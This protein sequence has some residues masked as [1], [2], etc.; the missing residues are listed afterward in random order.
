MRI[1]SI[2]ILGFRCFSCDGQSVKLDNLT[3]LVGPNASGKTATMA[4]LLRMFGE[5]QAERT[6][7][8]ADFYLSPGEKIESVPQRHLVLEA[9]IVFPEL[10][11]GISTDAIPE[12]F[13][14]MMVDQPG[15]APYC[16]IRLEADWTAD[17]TAAGDVQQKLFWILT[18]SDDEAVIDEKRRAVK[19]G[20]RSRVRVVYVP[21]T[22]DPSQQIRT[23]TASA[24][25]RLLGAI[26]W[27]GKDGGV[28]QTLTAL[29]TE[30]KQLQGIG[31]LDSKIQESW[32]KLYDGR[33]AATVSL[34]GVDPDP[35]MLLEALA[36]SF[37]P[38]E[39]GQAIRSAALSDGLRSLFALSLPLGIHR[40]EQLLKANAAALGFQ[41]SITDGL[42]LLT[43]FAV[44]EPEN[45]LS[46][47]Y[48]GKV[49][50]EMT[51][52]SASLGAQVVVS[53]HSPSIMAR[54]APDAVRYFL[55]GETRSSTEVRSLALPNDAGDEAFK[56]V[57]EA[58]CGHPELYFSRVVVLGEGPSEEIILRKLFDASGSP[59]DALFVSVVPLGGRHVN[60]F[61]R[62][63]IG[64]GIPF[65]TLLDLDLEKEG[66][67]WGRI[68]YVR[69]QLVKLY[70]PDSDRLK[71]NDPA[72]NARSLSEPEYD[73]LC[74]NDERTDGDEMTH[75][76]SF[77]RLNYSVFF[78]EPLDIDLAMLE[79]FKGEYQAQAPTGGG[80]R[81]PALQP[82]RG[83]AVK[84]RM[85]WVLAADPASAQAELGSS[86]S[87]DQVE[88][89][90]W[91]KYLFIDGS[92]P[93]AHMRALLNIPKDRLT[94]E[95]PEALRALVACVHALGFP[96]PSASP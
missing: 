94:G 71:F 96:A 20:E 82:A 33:I 74:R 39:Q 77:F 62:L 53:S 34:E 42:P 59:L 54:V 79:A 5:T 14:Q 55:G 65:V 30:L 69:D 4:A 25:G 36:P 26:E 15:G 27:G 38:N 93:V 9:R 90:P 8:P 50:L 83:K 29:N 85:R 43:V 86:Y 52:A 16:R 84:N 13:N 28:R 11:N 47:H 81:L 46:P 73:G 35:S 7:R 88:L 78:S 45:H 23:T 61:W 41:A 21:A 2:F 67:G 72:G 68:Q 40:V 37:A 75:W 70:G 19:P 3:C 60:H 6:V 56:Y 76:I 80:P 92:K 1:D 64:L 18:A 31:T 87:T 63:L 22:R 51:S 57:R 66:A 12:T 10:A 58:V 24:F 44:E 48:L 17:G 49:I 91:Y 89:F 95:A 32:S